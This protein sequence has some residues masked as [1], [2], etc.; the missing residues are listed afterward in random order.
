M[1]SLI[2]WFNKQASLVPESSVSEFKKEIDNLF[3]NFFGSRWPS[4]FFA[5]TGKF[6]PAFD[7]KET[8]NDLVL[9]A[10]LPGVDPSEVEVKLCG[11]LLEIKGEKKEEKEEKGES[12]HTIERSYGSFTRSFRLP[13]DVEED[14]VEANFKNGVLELKLPKA[15]HEK[16]AVRKIEVKQA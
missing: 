12:R 14:K 3:E 5:E 16:K 7:I 15:Q 1:S 2:P 11:N 8:E 10:E 9:T 4:S 6:I 13:C